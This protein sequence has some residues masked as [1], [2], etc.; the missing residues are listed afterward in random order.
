MACILYHISETKAA[1][2]ESRKDP[3]ANKQRIGRSKTVKINNAHHL[4]IG[5]SWYI[6][7]HCDDRSDSG[8]NVNEWIQFLCVHTF[9]LFDEFSPNIGVIQHH[10]LSF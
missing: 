7:L 10:L 2:K 8:D 5:T 6:T 9:Q 3:D 4:Q 1:S